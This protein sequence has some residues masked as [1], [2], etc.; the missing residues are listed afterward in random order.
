MD[1]E[2]P[3]SGL[4]EES[5]EYEALIYRRDLICPAHHTH[6]RMETDCPAYLHHSPLHVYY[7]TEERMA[8]YLDKIKAWFAQGYTCK[9]ADDWHHKRYCASPSVFRVWLHSSGQVIPHQNRTSMDVLELML[10]HMGEVKVSAALACEIAGSAYAWGLHG[11]VRS[12]LDQFADGI[13]IQ[14]ISDIYAF[15]ALWDH[16]RARGEG[17]A[18]DLATKEDL[19]GLCCDWVDD[20]RDLPE[21]AEDLIADR[22]FADLHQPL[23]YASLRLLDPDDNTWYDSGHSNQDEAEPSGPERWDLLIRHLLAR[24]VALPPEVAWLHKQRTAVDHY[25]G[26]VSLGAFAVCMLAPRGGG[27]K[28]MPLDLIRSILKPMLVSTME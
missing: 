5:P 27:M 1:D 8:R 26:Y 7:K 9:D 18:R 24:G 16:L 21:F 20:L 6:S 13:C 2:C 17:A 14:F 10:N 25:R 28:R 23:I 15:E 12:I 22:K 3:F 19:D 11:I 4:S